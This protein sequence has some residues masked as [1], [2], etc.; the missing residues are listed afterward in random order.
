MRQCQSLN[1]FAARLHDSYLRL[2]GLLWCQQQPRTSD[3][4]DDAI[5]DA[6]ELAGATML[7]LQQLQLT[8]P[9]YLHRRSATQPGV[10]HV[11]RPGW[12]QRLWRRPEYWQLIICINLTEINLM[13]VPAARPAWRRGHYY[14]ALQLDAGQ[15]TA[16]RAAVQHKR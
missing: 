9:C 15:I 2:F 4:A 7:Q 14:F 16:L 10:L 6:A 13:L 8:L 12:W 3:R 1:D 5:A 11:A